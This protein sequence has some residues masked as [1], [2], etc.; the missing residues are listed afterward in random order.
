VD[1]PDLGACAEALQAGREVPIAALVPSGRRAAPTDLDR[2]RPAHRLTRPIRRARL[3]ECLDALRSQRPAPLPLA[4]PEAEALP[5]AAKPAAPPAPAA[6]RLGPRVLVADDYPANQRLVTR[7]LEKRGCTVETVSDGSAAVEAALGQR[8]D[9]VLMDCNMPI[10]DGYEA[11]ARI[12]AGEQGRRTPILAM[13]AADSPED[14]KTCLDAGMDDYLVKP[15]QA[16]LV[17]AA[18]ERWAA[19]QTL[20]PASGGLA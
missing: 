7:L 19:S 10:L 16:A 1:A 14:R 11:T 9:V 8:F 15:I 12:R 17:I 5:V 4:E 6:G 18:V 20:V 2:Q 13:T 3:V